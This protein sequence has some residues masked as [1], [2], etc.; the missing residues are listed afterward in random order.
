MTQERTREVSPFLET[1]GA[2]TEESGNGYAR[3]SLLL[4]PRHS[5]SIVMHGGV[6]MALA[7]EAMARAVASTRTPEEAKTSA[8]LGVEMNLSFM[9]SAQSGDEVIVEGRVIRVG[10]SVAFAEVEARRRG[11]EQLIAKGRQVFAIATRKA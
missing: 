3:I 2:K 7:D 1:L 5:N 11:D 10:K 6:L 9:R 4:E 8:F